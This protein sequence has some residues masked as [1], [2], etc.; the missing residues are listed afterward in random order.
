MDWYN[1]IRVVKLE[2]KKVAFL[3][4]EE[5]DVSICVLVFNDVLNVVF[6]SWV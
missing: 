4:R 1:V 2:R 3:D 6:I 5:F